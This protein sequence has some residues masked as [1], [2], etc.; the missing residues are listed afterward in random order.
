MNLKKQ[1]DGKT[2][3]PAMSLKEYFSSRRFRYGSAATAFIAVVIVL[4]MALNI[5]TSYLDDRYSLRI[6]TS[7]NQFFTISEKTTDI[8]EALEK[9]VTIYVLYPENDFPDRVRDFVKLYAKHSDRITVEFIDPDRNPTF[10]Q[11]FDTDTTISRASIIVTAG[12][13]F[14]VLEYNN[15]FG[16]SSAS[17]FYYP[18]YDSFYGELRIT[19]AIQYV[20]SDDLPVVYFT[21]GHGE[22]FASVIA[23]FFTDS[24][25]IVKKINLQES[26][27][28][29]DAEILVIFEPTRDF[30]ADE[31]K[32][33]DGMLDSYR[34]VMY[35]ASAAVPSLPV[36][37]ELLAEWG[38]GVNHD[39]VYDPDSSYQSSPNVVIAKYLDEEFCKSLIDN[40]IYT[41]IPNSRSLTK[42]FDQRDLISV[43]G[44][45]GTSSGAYAKSL[46]NGSPTTS[47]KEDG[48]ASGP[49]NIAMLAAKAGVIDNVYVHPA[50]SWPAPSWRMRR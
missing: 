19:G 46:A 43:A 28:P 2:S 22:T 26:D 12:D 41:L 23:N 21:E 32:K 1:K 20:C 24:N 14:R 27:I 15:L 30:T 40:K 6:D 10:T 39:I 36:L 48:D 13:N 29:E 34:N 38:I 17:S 11:Q 49:F 37:E 8:L 35:L 4:V 31:V 50:C 18:T 9:D 25:C 16:S 44:L 3:R 42:L 7:S 45:L 47:E 33:V 5:L